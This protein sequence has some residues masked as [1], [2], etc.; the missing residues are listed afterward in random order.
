MDA[1]GPGRKRGR[2]LRPWLIQLKLAGLG[3][4]FG[5]DAA[6][7]AIGSIGP[8]PTDAATWDFLREVMRAVFWPCVFGG[9]VVT[10]V[11]GIALFSHHPGVFARTR[12]FRLKFVLLLVCVPA[13]H[14]AARGRVTALYAAIDAGDLTALPPLQ[15]QV[16]TAFAVAF[17]VM[18]GIAVIGKFKPR[19]GERPG[20]RTPRA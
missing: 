16:T 9:L 3:L 11:A 20:A 8:R 17:V 2:G 14:L 15:D 19:L 4:F 10:I 7:V 13:L 5:G 1:P 6:L 18:A 12:W